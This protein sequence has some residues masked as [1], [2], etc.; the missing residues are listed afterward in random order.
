MYEQIHTWPN[1]LLA[2]R[3]ASQGK[4]GQ[5]NVAAFEYRLEDNLLLLRDELAS[6]TYRP[7]PYHQLLHP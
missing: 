3:R 7:A 1:L 4:R 2:Y 5:P 6:Q